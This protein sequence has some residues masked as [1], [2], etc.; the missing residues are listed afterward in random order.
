ME[1]HNCLTYYVRNTE[2]GQVVALVGEG[3]FTIGK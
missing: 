3:E 1:A 2:D